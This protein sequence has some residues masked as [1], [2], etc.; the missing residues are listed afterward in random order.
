[1]KNKVTELV[2]H[3]EP[4]TIAGNIVGGT[5]R[6]RH[7]DDRHRINAQR[8]SEVTTEFALHRQHNTSQPLRCTNR[9]AHR[10][11]LDDV[12]DRSRIPGNT[13]DLQSIVEIA[14]EHWQRIRDP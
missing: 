11:I 6:T 9:I 1:M 8:E 3:C 12:R 4:L 10:R 14:V 7:A 2:R 5:S 13:F